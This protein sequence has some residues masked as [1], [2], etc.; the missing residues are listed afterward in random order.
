[1]AI[2]TWTLDQDHWIRVEDLKPPNNLEVWAYEPGI[3]VTK[4]FHKNNRM[5]SIYPIGWSRLGQLT[6][7]DVTHWQRMV[8]PLPPRSEAP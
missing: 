4:A 3:G 2:D 6:A 1:M 8:P 7:L 5:G